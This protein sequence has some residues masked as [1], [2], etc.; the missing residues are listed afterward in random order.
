MHYCAIILKPKKI[1]IEE[2]RNTVGE[3]LL[4]RNECDWFVTDHHNRLFPDGREC[5][6][7]KEYV[8]LP[9][10]YEGSVVP[11]FVLNN[12][13]N[14]EDCIIPSKFWEFYDL[15][16]DRQ[17]LLDAYELSYYKQIKKWFEKYQKK[18]YEILYLDYHN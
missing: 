2:A 11:V 7:L 3:I 1:D 16:I 18:N 10:I 13:G 4:N 12:E 5:I 6:P 14:D 15:P 8:L 17:I 9:N